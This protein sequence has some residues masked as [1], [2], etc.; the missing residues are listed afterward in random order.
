[1]TLI[2]QS[3][4]S[5]ATRINQGQLVLAHP[6]ALT[7]SIVHV[8]VAGGLLFSNATSFTIRGLTGGG[9]VNLTNVANQAVGLTV[10]G[11]DNLL[12][13]GVLAGSG[14]LTKNGSAR[15]ELT[16]AN[17]Y[18]G[19]TVLNA[20][21]LTVNNPTGSGLG[22]GSVTING[23]TL[24]G[25]GAIAGAV[26]VNATGH[27][28]P[29][30]SVG[31]QN[32]GSLTL[33]NGS[34]LD[35]EFGGS[36]NDLFY[37]DN[38]N[39][40]TINDGAK[41]NLYIEDTLTAFNSL[42]TYNLINYYGDIGGVGA[43]GLSVANFALNRSYSFAE[44]LG[45]SNWVVMTIGGAGSGWVGATN[46]SF[47]SSFGNWQTSGVPYA[48]QAGDQLVFDGTVRVV[49]TNDFPNHTA[50]NGILFNNSPGIGNF[51]LRGLATG[52]NIVNLTG[53]VLNYSTKSQT[54]DL[55]LN[56]VGAT[57]TFRANGTL[58]VNGDITENTA[59]LG[60]IKV[61]T[62]VLVLN[63]NNSYS[64]ATDIRAGA[65]RAVDGAGLPVAS[66]LKLNGGVFESS[67][68]FLRSTGT[69]AGA[70]Q[71][72]SS[73]GFSASGGTLTVNLGGSADVLTWGNP[74][75]VPNS[76]TLMF[77]AASAD[78]TVN[79]L[80][81]INFGSQMRT[82]QVA[83]GSAYVDADLGG[84]LTGS[85][86]LVKTGTGALRLSGVNTFSGAAVINAGTL[87]VSG[88][89]GSGADLTVSSGGVLAG[90]GII[91]RAITGSGTISPGDSPGI[92][93][94]DQVNPS[95]N[96]TFNFDFTNLGSP[97]YTQPSASLNDV[98]RITNSTPFTAAL[99]LGNTVNL[100]ISGVTLVVGQTNWFR[101]G[102]Y[103]DTNAAFD[104]WITGGTYQWYYNN[105]LVGAPAVVR[106]V[107]ETGTQFS[108]VNGYVMEFGVIGIN[109]AVVPEPQ[110]LTFWLAGL[111]VL[112]AARRRRV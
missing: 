83:N 43:A 81:P 89:I 85:G 18:T 71:W 104:A 3:S 70:V 102:F 77:S 98:L 42:G 13:S 55:D 99:G 24:G 40:L 22:T 2:G 38:V 72:I 34:F 86:G 4:Y 28:A 59:G 96:L 39:G 54:I 45:P 75:F 56:L 61:G 90:T 73:G 91:G 1:L 26:I 9:T 92:L 12:Y 27:L 30:N 23:G 52:T 44:V 29:G 67:G 19:G 88:S 103:T 48:V 87:I 47:W 108:G 6:T 112:Y 94:V 5:G 11:T 100:Y 68:S 57:R 69:V 7:N 93:T 76:R 15:L 62:G 35:V 65:L 8:N 17:T 74:G 110:V 107:D 16:A 32:Y 101:G 58:T 53:D 21:T 82:V 10:R 64:G 49:N 46:N 37:V 25:T 84:A 33:N 51:T 14:S 31:S 109:V 66:N 106:T 97:D 60:L 105:L 36:V 50:F 78:S 95:L 79:F 41:L 80:N 20:G 111:A 63:G